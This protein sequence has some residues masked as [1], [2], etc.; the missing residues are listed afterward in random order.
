[1]SEKR[2]DIFREIV[3]VLILGLVLVSALSIKIV[4]VQAGQTTLKPTDDT[5]VDDNNPDSNYSELSYLQVMNYESAYSNDTMIMWLKFSL[6][7]VPDGAVIDIATLSL[8]TSAVG[9]TYNVQAY[10]CSNIYWNELSITCNNM[11][12][13][14]MTSMDSVLVTTI[15]QWYNWNVVDAARNALN[16]NPKS[17]TIVMQEPNPHSSAKLVW[18]QSKDNSIY[19]TDYSPKLAIHWSSV[20]PEFP[21]FLILPLFMIATLLTVMVYRKKHTKILGSRARVPRSFS[22]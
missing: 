13:Y 17:V 11:P 10:S 5:Y 15:N 14:N 2:T 4:N 20:V 1:M 6:S 12:S 22:S 21:P 7:S 16:G 19:V 8:F 18:F 9:E 3:I